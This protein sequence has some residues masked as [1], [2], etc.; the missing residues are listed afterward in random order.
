MNLV[1]LYW[2][3]QH[4][5]KGPRLGPDLRGSVTKLLPTK[6]TYCLTCLHSFLRGTA[7]KDGWF[8]NKSVLGAGGAGD[9][10]RSKTF[11]WRP[12]YPN[13]PDLPREVGVV[14]ELKVWSQE[15]LF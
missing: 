12:R 2:L 1:S 9:C 7:A 3:E 6:G 11:L 10:T 4:V 15:T 5:A 8:V 14:A 13:V